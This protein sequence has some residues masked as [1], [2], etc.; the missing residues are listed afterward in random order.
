MLDDVAKPSRNEPLN[1]AK[2]VADLGHKQSI[3]S[4]VSVK[5]SSRIASVRNTIDLQI[6]KNNRL[7]PSRSSNVMSLYLAAKNPLQDDQYIQGSEDLLKRDS[8][9][10]QYA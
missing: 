10:E 6:Y 1:H 3:D 7:I 4:L 2:S 8:K 5:S 9:H